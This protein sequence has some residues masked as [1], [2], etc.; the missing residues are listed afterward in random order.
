[1]LASKHRLIIVDEICILLDNVFPAVIIQPGLIKYSLIIE[2]K[3][4]VTN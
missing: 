3:Y 4:D 1:M 2:E